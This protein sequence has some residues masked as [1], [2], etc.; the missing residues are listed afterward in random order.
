[1]GMTYDQLEK[2]IRMLSTKEKAALAVALLNELDSRSDGD[3]EK[4]WMD[5]AERRYD[6]FL[7]GGTES[8][9]AEEVIASAKQRFECR[10]PDI[11]ESRN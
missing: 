2:E 5:E 1:M 8:I 7:A 11:S 4:L 3:V 10:R 9:P 6:A